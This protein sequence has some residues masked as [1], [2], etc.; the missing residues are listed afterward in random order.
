MR[1]LSLTLV[2]HCARL[3]LS[4]TIEHHQHGETPLVD[5]DGQKKMDADIQR[6]RISYGSQ[7]T[8]PSS[9]RDML[10]ALEVM[11]D[12]YFDIF[13]ATWP[14]AI[15]WTAAVMGTH[16]SATLSSIVASLDP[17]SSTCT[18]KLAWQNTVDG[19]FAH[20]LA[21]YFGENAFAVR[22]QAYDDMLWVVLGWLENLKF[23]EMYSL[24]HWDFMQPGNG[25]HG[26][27][28]GPM[29]AHRARVF[30]D[31][32]SVGWDESLCGGGMTWNPHLTPYKNS[33][34]NE[35]FTA[36]SISMY[37]YFPGDNNTSPYMSQ[38][39]DGFSKPHHP[40]Y[41]ENAIK[42][43]K[44]LQESR[45]RNPITGLYQDGFHV[46][47][48]HRYS[49]GTVNPGTE[50]CDDLNAMTYTYN[51]GV[52]LTASRGLWLATGAR[53]YLDDGHSLVQDVIRATGWPNT[54][55]AWAGMGRGGVL[56]EFCDHQ[57]YCSQ[58]G[59]TFKGIFFHHLS[60]FCR[61]LWP[62]EEAFV[63]R[64]NTQGFDHKLYRYH[65]A[66]CAAYDKWVAH[67]ANA[68][69]ATKDL[70][71]HFGMWWTFD[72]PDEED[73]KGINDTTFIQ[74]GAD[75]YVNPIPMDWKLYS[76][77]DINDRGR[78]RTVETQS[79]GLSVLRARWTWEAH[80]RKIS[81]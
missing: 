26:L 54:D 43:Y 33:I 70:S 6:E 69:L 61:P 67:N 49:N 2:L 71:G 17:S 60:E 24:R 32:A 42:S 27:Q 79:G 10:N 73:M 62:Q 37:L 28:F 34:T 65:L 50:K 25:W 72:E 1:L 64:E 56:E 9:L 36:A 22:N 46:T 16:V 63:A 11:Q 18:D 45:M 47:G 68:A 41:L 14:D 53:S 12:T 76:S 75:D 23:A 15:D 78:G 80:L 20:T 5:D 35:L 57:G 81:I 38:G 48:W 31:L 66:R 4:R 21:F 74:P 8:L 58:D 30:Y 44:W 7:S 40:L 13:S 59:Q 19:Y 3:V 77:K 29:A 39:S 55:A 52:I 51:Q